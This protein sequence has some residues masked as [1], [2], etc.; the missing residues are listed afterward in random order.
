MTVNNVSDEINKLLEEEKPEKVLVVVLTDCE[1]NSSQMFSI[2]D[3][4]Q[5]ITEKT[6]V[7]WEF[8]YI[9]ANQDTWSV[10]NSMGIASAN[11]ISYTCSVVRTPSL[12]M[13]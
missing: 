6:L 12:R 7:G 13:N 9:G 1:E 3:V 2:Q 10:A 8:V 11:A 4:R 5:L